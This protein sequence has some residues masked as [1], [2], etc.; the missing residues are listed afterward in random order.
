MIP[1]YRV[2]HRDVTVET[3]I[4]SLA[5]NKLVWAGRTK[6][7]N[8]KSVDDLVQSTADAVGAQLAAAQLPYHYA[9]RR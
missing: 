3:R 5:D 4:Y 9:L 8:P 1:G 7:D 6:T 2:D